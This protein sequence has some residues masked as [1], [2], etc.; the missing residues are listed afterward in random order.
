MF[1]PAPQ[2]I[3][4]NL[5]PRLLEV[6]LYQAALESNASEHSARMAAMRNA[7]EAAND[8][9]DE[10]TLIYNQVRQASITNEIAEIASGKAALE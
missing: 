2:A 1:E 7:S 8:M 3:L 5:L 9:I 4:D 10:L 6:Q